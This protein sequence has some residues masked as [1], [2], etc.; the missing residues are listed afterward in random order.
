MT[1]FARF[2]C[3]ILSSIPLYHNVAAAGVVFFFLLRCSAFPILLLSQW[4]NIMYMHLAN[5]NVTCGASKPYFACLHHIKLNNPSKWHIIII[6]SII[7]YLQ[8]LISFMPSSYLWCY[9]GCNLKYSLIWCIFSLLLA[10]WHDLVDD[11]QAPPLP[12]RQQQQH[13]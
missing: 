8:K 10:I 2:D 9:F 11:H 5:S 12:Q 6:H 1:F 7:Y 4:V 3:P 13:T